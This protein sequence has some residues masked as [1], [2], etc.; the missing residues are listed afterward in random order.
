MRYKPVKRIDASLLE[1]PA[2]CIPSH[3][4]DGCMNFTM[5][6]ARKLS[7]LNHA[8]HSVEKQKQEQTI[9][10]QKSWQAIKYS[11][12]ALFSSPAPLDHTQ[13][14]VKGQGILLM[15]LRKSGRLK[16]RESQLEGLSS[17]SHLTSPKETPYGNQASHGLPY[18]YKSLQ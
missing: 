17:T 6:S 10:S 7:L 9:A 5:N 4:K 13:P 3:S 16:S 8:H 14:K 12:C 2:A 18:N 1:L 11:G 15:P